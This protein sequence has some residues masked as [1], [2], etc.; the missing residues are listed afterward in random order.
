MMPEATV[1]RIAHREFPSPN[2]KG[3]RGARMNTEAQRETG[4]STVRQMNAPAGRAGNGSA[5]LVALHGGR[6][7]RRE[8]APHQQALARD[9]GVNAM[10]DPKALTNHP[11]T[12]VRVRALVRALREIPQHVRK[13]LVR[14]L[15]EIPCKDISA[16]DYLV[17]GTL[18]GLSFFEDLGHL[19]GV[20]VVFPQP[21]RR[22]HL[23]AVHGA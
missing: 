4:S 6:T 16:D 10:I 20:R 23:S 22:A 14:C 18:Q 9:T 8:E 21:R 5:V 17:A 13:D 15:R 3:Q 7:G 11:A 19:D 12:L 1:P 2:P